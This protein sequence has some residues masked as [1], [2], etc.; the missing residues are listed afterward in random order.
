MTTPIVRSIWNERFERRTEYAVLCTECLA[1]GSTGRDSSS[2][3]S[4]NCRQFEAKT[5]DTSYRI[6][7]TFRTS[8]IDPEADTV[9]PT[10]WEEC[11]G[12]SFCIL[13]NLPPTKG[14]AL[15]KLP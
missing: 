4:I 13:M 10:R 6:C 7:G 5:R 14:F 12:Q 2:P 9:I 11:L 8:A 15:R 1:L 3:S